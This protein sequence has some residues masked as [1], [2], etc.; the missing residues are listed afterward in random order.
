MNNANFDSL[1][2]FLW[3][4]VQKQPITQQVALPRARALPGRRRRRQQQRRGGGRQR[5]LRRRIHLRQRGE[6]SLIFQINL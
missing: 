1:K 5:G 2:L 4:N 6:W 3:K